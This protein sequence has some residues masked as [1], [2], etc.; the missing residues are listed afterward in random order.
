MRTYIDRPLPHIKKNKIPQHKGT[1]CYNRLIRPSPIIHILS[2]RTY[3]N[4]HIQPKGAMLCLK[5]LTRA[6]TAAN[7]FSK[8]ISVLDLQKKWGRLW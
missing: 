3:I 6:P 1:S 8:V 4:F 2:Y 5:I 7:K